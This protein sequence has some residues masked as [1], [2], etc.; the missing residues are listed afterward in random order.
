MNWTTRDQKKKTKKN[1]DLNKKGSVKPNKSF[2]LLLSNH[3]SRK[4]S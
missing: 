4:K 1:R 2:E 3:C